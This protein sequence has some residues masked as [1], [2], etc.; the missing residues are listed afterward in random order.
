MEY[1]VKSVIIGRKKRENKDDIAHPVFLSLYKEINDGH[2]SSDA[3]DEIVEFSQTMEVVIKGL[4][5]NY[6]IPIEISG[7]F[8]VKIG[9]EK[10][11][12]NIIVP[13]AVWSI[14]EV[15]R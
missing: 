9:Q 12:C 5:V 10:W 11:S 7:D 2:K 4:N 8:R 13:G 6:L 15:L 1:N 3:P 14:G